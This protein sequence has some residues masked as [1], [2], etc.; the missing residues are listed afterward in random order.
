MTTPRTRMTW[1]QSAQAP[2][3]YGWTPDHPAA[4]PDPA[5][6]AYENGDTSSW[7]EDPTKGPY[8]QGPAP[9]SQ[10]WTPSHPAA[11]PDAMGP[12]PPPVGPDS[13][14]TAAAMRARVEA[15][16]AKC[17]RVASAILGKGASAQAVENKALA[18]M[19]LP[20]ARIA[21]ALAMVREAFLTGT[22]PLADQNDPEAYDFTG[23]MDIEVPM[24]AEAEEPK[25]G[26]QRSAEDL[27][28]EET[29]Q[30]VADMLA[31]KHSDDFEVEEV[32]SDEDEALLASMM[33]GE[34]DHMAGEDEDPEAEAMLAEMLGGKHA[35]GDVDSKLAAENEKLKAEL[36][37]L[38][39]AG[40]KAEAPVEAEF[41]AMGLGDEGYGSDD[42]LGNLFGR[43]AGKKAEDEG[44]DA[45]EAEDEAEKKA[46]KKA[47]LLQQA[48]KLAKLAKK[49]ADDDGDKDEDELEEVKKEARKLAKLVRKLAA[50]E[51]DDDAAKEAEDEA[52]ADEKKAGKKAYHDLFA[53]KKA[54]DDEDGDEGV[55]F[56]SDEGEDDAEAAKKEARLQPQARKAS[57]GVRTL[58]AVRVASQ[59]NSNDLSRLWKTAPD[60]SEHF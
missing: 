24:M 31:G 1:K 39:A 46:G 32:D 33:A 27:E 56:S 29:A 28:A 14:K 36:A 26:G 49:L 8:P 60:V 30:M 10:S 3:S 13:G 18:L 5:A 6:D 9:S 41:D 22:G 7:A 16:A 47:Y 51:D 44:E 52:E 12:I 42:V 17:I 2:A 34:P 54:D 21:M 55:E 57:T 4:L 15:K 40:K 20:D 37:A 59:D 58:G 23:E 35:G 25:M 11:K 48:A 50:D 45:K 53:G 43:T 19:D 38:K